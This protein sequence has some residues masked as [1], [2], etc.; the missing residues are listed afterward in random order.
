[1]KKLLV[2]VVLLTP[3]VFCLSAHAGEYKIIDG[4]VS[5]PEYHKTNFDAPFVGSSD[6][7]R[8]VANVNFATPTLTNLGNISLIAKDDGTYETASWGWDPEGNQ[9]D[10]PSWYF[11]AD[12]SD[13]GHGEID[14]D[15]DGNMGQ[16]DNSYAV[17]RGSCSYS[18]EGTNVGHFTPVGS[19]FETTPITR[20]KTFGPNMGTLRAPAVGEG[21]YAASDVVT[22]TF[23]AKVHAEVQ[24]HAGPGPDTRA[25]ASSGNN[26]V[27]FSNCTVNPS[28][29]NNENHDP[30]PG[31]GQILH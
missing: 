10:A 21:F 23:S 8:G 1:M 29:K 15:G 28:I 14:V 13:S 12:C 2:A 7:A 26:N 5:W 9:P 25:Y 20:T 30:A 17:S 6:H 3:S 27:S 11:T 4:T 16:E 22:V 18:L 31:G 24:A 19:G